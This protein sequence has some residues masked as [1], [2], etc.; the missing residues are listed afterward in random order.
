MWVIYSMSIAQQLITIY[1]T[2]VQEKVEIDDSE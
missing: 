2:P 1:N